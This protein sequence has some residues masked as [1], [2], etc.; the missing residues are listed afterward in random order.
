MDENK[1]PNLEEYL[2]SLENLAYNAYYDLDLSNAP[3][4]VLRPNGSGTY[5]AEE[6]PTVY[7]DYKHDDEY[8][9]FEP[10][11]QFP[12]MLK[13]NDYTG[14]YHSHMNAWS[15]AA[16]LADYLLEASWAFDTEFED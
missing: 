6:M 8:F 2:G 5:T 1:F 3:N 12:R 13:T 15:E 16:K 11:M 4:V 7:G 9:W 14:S 10:R